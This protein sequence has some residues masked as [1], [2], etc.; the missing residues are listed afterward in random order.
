MEISRD[1]F[2]SLKGARI[3]RAFRVVVGMPNGEEVI[4][5]D[6]IVIKANGELIQ[7]LTDPSSP[8]LHILAGPHDVVVEGDYADRISTELR[9]I[10]LD[11]LPL[12]ANQVHVVHEVVR[13][14][15][16]RFLVGAVL[17]EGTSGKSLSITTHLD[18][19]EIGSVEVLMQYLGRLLPGV[20]KI[21]IERR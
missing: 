6:T 13:D 3:E 16:R 20:S 9:N 4:L 17:S 1:F 21:E 14:P 11:T 18:D 5:P 8:H 15:N 10:D 2:D 7:L 19:L 12:Q